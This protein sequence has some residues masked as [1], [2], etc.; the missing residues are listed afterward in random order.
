FEAEDDSSQTGNIIDPNSVQSRITQWETSRE[1]IRNALKEF[2]KEEHLKALGVVPEDDDPDIKAAYMYDDR[3]YLNDLVTKIKTGLAQGKL[4]A[5]PNK[6]HAWLREIMRGVSEIAILFD[7]ADS[8]PEG[9]EV[10]IIQSTMAVYGFLQLG[11]NQEVSAQTQT[12]LISKAV[13]LEAK[14]LIGNVIDMCRRNKQLDDV[15]AKYVSFLQLLLAEAGEDLPASYRELMNQVAKIG[16]SYHAQSLLMA[17]ICREIV[18]HYQNMQTGKSAHHYVV[19]QNACDK[20]LDMLKD[21]TEKLNASAG[22]F[23]VSNLASFDS[24]TYDTHTCATLFSEMAVALQE[25]SSELGVDTS[26]AEKIYEK[27]LAKAVQQDKNRM[28]AARDRIKKIKGDILAADNTQL[29]DVDV[30]VQSVKGLGNDL[31]VLTVKVQR[32]ALL[33]VLGWGAAQKSNLKGQITGKDFKFEQKIAGSPSSW[34]YVSA[35]KNVGSLVKVD[36]KN[37]EL[38][39]IVSDAKIAVDDNALPDGNS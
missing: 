19:I 36:Q 29:V 20:T 32:S 28:I 25:F 12:Y 6:Q 26:D 3:L 15:R 2:N 10:V 23:G 8:L 38:R 39:M 18:K 5:F 30:K 11:S 16:R 27:R 35:D 17:T 7:Q 22:A 21:V 34:K 9:S 13:C 4:S 14:L 31:G 24:T 33:S 1:Y 37:L